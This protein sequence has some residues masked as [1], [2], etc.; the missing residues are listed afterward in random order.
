[1]IMKPNLGQWDVSKSMLWGGIG[2]CFWD[3]LTFLI[4]KWQMLL[5]NFFS[6]FFIFSALNLKSIWSCSSLLATMRQWASGQKLT[7][8]EWGIKMTE[9][10]WPWWHCWV[11]RTTCLHVPTDLQVKMKTSICL[12]QSTISWVFCFLQQMCPY[13][14]ASELSGKL[15]KMQISRSHPQKF[16]FN[17]FIIGPRSQYF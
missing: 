16:P 6:P 10:T 3:S 8:Q 1:M 15:V 11:T 13:D 9:R 5:A 2:G 12:G 14:T 4:K 7:H 17:M